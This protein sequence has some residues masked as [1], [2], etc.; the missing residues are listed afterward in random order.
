MYYQN[1]LSRANE[2]GVVSMALSW[3]TEEE[4]EE[5]LPKRDPCWYFDPKHM[6]TIIKFEKEN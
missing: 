6:F 1:F 4:G 2:Y 5:T 3:E